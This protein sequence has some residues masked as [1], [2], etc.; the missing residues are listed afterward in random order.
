VI[1][2]RYIRVE[3]ALRRGYMYRQEDETVN[4]IWM[5]RVYCHHL[6]TGTPTDD[7][8]RNENTNET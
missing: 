5:T 2:E 3:Y 8:I 7:L 1:I 4:G 6:N